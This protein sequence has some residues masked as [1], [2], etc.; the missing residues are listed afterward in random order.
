MNLG[1]LGLQFSFG[2]QQANMSPIWGYLGAEE[3]NFAWLGIAGPLTGLI[4]QPIIGSLSDR[5]A[6]RWGRRT[7]YF[8]AGAVMCALGLFLMPLS[9][10]VLMA[11]SLLFLL[12]VGN[13]V[14]MEPYRAYVN[15]RLEADQRGF[16]FLS[17]SAFTGLAQCLAYLS[18]TLLVT[19]F[20][21]SKDAT[22]G[23]GIPTFTLVS[24]WI[25]AVLSLGTILWSITR[26]PELKL[27]DAERAR[28]AALPKNPAATLGEIVSAMREMPKAMKAM[29]WMSLF[30][31]YAMS[32]Y[33]GYVTNSI[34]RSVYGTADASTAAYRD[35]VLT[36]GQIGAFF[37]LIAF[38]S[39]LAMAPM[40]RRVGA[41]RLHAF[42]LTLSGFAMLA[43]PLIGV[44]ELL[45]VAAI[46]IGLGWGSI[47]G[48]PYIILADTIPPER[49]GVYMG[50]F[51]MFICVP[52]LV[53]AGT[54]TFAYEP[55]L[56]GDARNV[57]RVSGVCM[58]LAAIAVWR[59]KE[60]RGSAVAAAG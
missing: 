30:Q 33:W 32:G 12:D 56:G 54:M 1:F 11:F 40:A 8:L 31:W 42:C 39:A 4:V 35:A 21:L 47:M 60:G 37:N 38:V 49:T 24:F 52:M 53:F 48:N 16:G 6:S 19:W 14:T 9:A 58:L 44:K 27:P 57:L 22:A 17:Q 13:N 51:N 28:L 7:P 10:S 23:G 50:I 18:P 15:D 2:L 5:T 25:G 26:V 59:I 3:K 55:L 20:G 29:A 36:N 45:F 46:G 34:S 43:M 41:G